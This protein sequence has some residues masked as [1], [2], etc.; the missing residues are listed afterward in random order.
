MSPNMQ[1]IN[2]NTSAAPGRTTV[3][4]TMLY[5]DAKTRSKTAK[6]QQVYRT[7]TQ[8][9]VALFSHLPQY[10]RENSFSLNIKNKD[11]IHPLVIE[12]G[13]LFAEMKIVGANARCVSMLNAFKHASTLW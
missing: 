10:E 1:T 11:S 12:L 4:N 13:L 6:K 3:P 8:K 5:D 9:L 2:L 7:P